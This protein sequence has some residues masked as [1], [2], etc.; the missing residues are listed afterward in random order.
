MMAA[1]EW[2]VGASWWRAYGERLGNS[3]SVG[4]S[5]R[6]MGSDW[7]LVVF[8]R[9]FSVLFGWGVVVVEAVWFSSDVVMGLVG[10]RLDVGWRE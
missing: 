2:S 3:A 4:R 7:P 9:R 5:D 6:R 1:R 8:D 10:V